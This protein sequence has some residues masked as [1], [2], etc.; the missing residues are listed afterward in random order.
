[1]MDPGTLANAAAWFA[2]IALIVAAASI[3]PIVLR[4]DA[5]DVR[6]L[7]WRAVLAGCLALPWLQG[8]VDPALATAQTPGVASTVA[9]LAPASAGPIVAA[10]P[11][12]DWVAIAL[13]IAITGAGVRLAWVGA[14]VLRLRRLRTA[15]Q[16]APPSADADDLQ[17]IIGTSAEIRYVPALVHPVTF[18]MRR[19][20]VLLPASLPQQPIEIQRA[21]LAHE[22]LHVSRRDWAWLLAEEVVRAAFWFHP[23]V[24]WLI[25]R[26]QLAREEVVDELAV[27]VTGHRRAYVEA[28]LAFAD[29]VPLTPAPAFARRRHLFRRML[30]ISREGR[31]SS[32]RIVA[33]A[34]VMVLVVIGGA[35]YAVDA[36]PLQ[37][38]GGSAA[39]L[40]GAGPAEQS[41]NPVTPENPVPRRVFSVAA[42][43][44]PIADAAGVNGKVTLRLTLNSSGRIVEA[45]PVGIDL[46]MQRPSL[47]VELRDPSSFQVERLFT[48]MAPESA[49][50]AMAVIEALIDASTASARQ[51]QYDPPFNAPIAFD[52]DTWFGQP[53]PPPPPPPVPARPAVAAPPPPAAPPAPAQ[54]TPGPPPPPPLP[55]PQRAAAGWAEHPAPDPYYDS[56]VRVGGSIRPPTK[57]KDVRP[58]YPL[59]AQQARIQGVVIV[60]GR[61][62]RDGRVSSVRVLRSIPLLDEAAIDAVQQWMTVNFRLE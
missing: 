1:M 61:I 39:T 19:P 47:S 58:V 37:G 48:R 51:W 17:R 10:A 33:S 21:V 62:E 43:M 3:L 9:R 38:T 27:L 35:W 40:W 12:L 42:E 59:V 2:Q 34:A 11:S 18:G 46:R 26:V 32:K 14:G 20:V 4:L 25:S 28:L 36:F 29:R 23:A 60:E 8:R 16:T 22:L 50:T 24:W 41:A 54:R 5:P 6:F 52:I 31:M 57:L 13:W 15:G 44:P 7:F 45:R 30:L 55:P 56:A 53:P 49:R